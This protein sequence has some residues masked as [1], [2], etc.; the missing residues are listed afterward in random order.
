MFINRQSPVKSSP[1][2]RIIKIRPIG[3]K[4]AAISFP[5]KKS[6]EELAAM[7]DIAAPTAIKNPAKIDFPNV[8]ATD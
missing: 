6:V 3:N 2:A 5:A 1:P 7:L 4:L 8:F